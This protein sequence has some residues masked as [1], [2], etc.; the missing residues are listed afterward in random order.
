M[1]SPANS[2][3]VV[4]VGITADPS[5]LNAAINTAAATAQKGGAQISQAFTSAVSPTQQLTVAAQQLTSAITNLNS[6]MSAAGGTSR[7][8]GSAFQQIGTH[9][10]GSGFSVRYLFLGLKDI[11]EGRGTFALAEMAN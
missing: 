5:Q 3:G 1:G 10:Q 8:L 6:T 2:L 7:A 11:A 4:S 9:A